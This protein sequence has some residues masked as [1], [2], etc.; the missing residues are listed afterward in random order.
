MDGKEITYVEMIIRDKSKMV[1]KEIP[2]VY[3]DGK[4]KRREIMRIRK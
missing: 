2:V 1:V 4:E 3:F